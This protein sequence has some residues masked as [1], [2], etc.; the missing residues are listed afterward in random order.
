MDWDR[1][2][3]FQ[4]V[5]QA[6]SLT[7]AGEVLNLSQSAVSRQISALE[8]SLGVSLFH[9]HA[10]GLVLTEQGEMLFRT[11]ERVKADVD[12]YAGALR[13]KSVIMLFEKASLR[14]RVTF[15]VGIHRL[16]GQAIY[17]DHSSQRI[18]QR[19]L[20]DENVALSD[21]VLA[22]RVTHRRRSVA[23]ATGLMD[24]ETAVEL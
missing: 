21:P 4:T 15:E 14:T 16:G 19:D 7:K 1:L 20:A 6:Q 23:A 8:E 17:F 18:G 24:H 11:A 5:A 9:R 2:R 22:D 13:G 3:V 12:A 10:R